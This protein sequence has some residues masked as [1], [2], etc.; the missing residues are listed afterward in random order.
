[1]TGSEVGLTDEELID[2]PGFWSR[3][4]LLPSGVRAHYMTSGGSG[5][6]VV[7]LHGGLVGSSGAAGWRSLAP[8]LG[9]RGFRVY[10]PDSVG[11]GHT[12]DPD[13]RYPQG[14]AGH[15][16]FLH[17]FVR[18]L[19]LDEFALGGNSMGCLNAVNYALAHPERVTRLALIAGGV[20][21]LVP[22]EEIARRDDRPTSEKPDIRSYDGTPEGMRR[23]MAALASDPDDPALADD[24]VVAMRVAAAARTRDATAARQAHVDDPATRVRLSTRGRLDELPIPTIYVYGADDVL[25]PVHARGYL[26]EDALPQWQFFYPEGCGHQA[27]NDRPDIVNPLFHE[28]LRDGVVS[29]ETAERAGI[30]RRRP[31]HPH[32]VAS[33]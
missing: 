12:L 24:A 9:E 10:C 15:V 25:S 30:S 32:L 16:D 21:D 20:G 28:F 18:A 14:P 33:S 17:D 11:F 5:P 26:Q 27:Q 31:E 19:C 3:W 8:Y 7:L 1:M 4:V 2:V 23:L 13:G 22:Q 29:R 6:A